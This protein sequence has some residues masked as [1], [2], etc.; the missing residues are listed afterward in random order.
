MGYGRHWAGLRAAVP[1][2]VYNNY[3]FEAP[4]GF[5]MIEV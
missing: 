1:E 4:A 5:L 2:I 3:Y